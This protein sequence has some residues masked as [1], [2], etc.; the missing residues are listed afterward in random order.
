MS[1]TADLA[2]RSRA[3]MQQENDLTLARAAIPAGI[4]QLEGFHLVAP[5]ERGFTVLLAE[6]TCQYATGFLQLDAETARLGGDPERARVLSERGVDLA[7]RCVS[8]ALEL[9]GDDWRHAVHEAPAALG[10]L[11]A[12]AGSSQQTG[13]FWLG[14]GLAGAGAMSPQR[15]ALLTRLPAALA[16]IERSLAIDETF[17]HGLGHVVVGAAYAA[18]PKFLGGDAERG[19]RHLE[20]AFA[21]TGQ[22]NL[23]ARVAL[24]RYYAVAIGDRALF[25]RTLIEVLQTAPAVWPEMRLANEMA[26]AQARLYLAAEATWFGPGL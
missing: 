19:R 20:R 8:Y 21:L 14:I 15:P 6:A 22:R 3:A 9:L 2:A 1:T 18:R 5:G 4:K 17:Q 12:A 11:I 7:L 25:R 16:M 23:V 10:P 26:H 24:A 13:L